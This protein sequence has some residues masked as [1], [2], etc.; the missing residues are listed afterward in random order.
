[1]IGFYVSWIFA[2][3]G[4]S[5]GWIYPF[6][7]LMVYYAL[8]LLRPQFTWH[9]NF[10]DVGNSPSFSQWAAVSTLIGW[11]IKGFGRM[12]MLRWVAVPMGGLALYLASGLYATY[13]NAPA[14]GQDGIDRAWEVL[15][16]QSK[17]GLMALITITLVADPSSVKIF[18]WVAVLS[19]GYLGETFNEWYLQSNVYLFF[20]GWGGIDNNGVA[21]VMVMGVPLAFFFIIN[22]KRWWMKVILFIATGAMVHTVLFS[23][24]RSGQLGLIMVATVLFFVALVALPRKGLTIALAVVFILITLRLAGPEVRARFATIWVDKSEM[25]AS[26]RSRYDTWNA[27]W[28]CIQ[29]HPMGV[30][31]RNFNL[32]SD[33]YGLPADK[34]VHNLFLQTAADYGILGMIGLAVFYVGTCYQAF[35]AALTATARRMGWPRYYCH[36]VTVS[37]AGLLTCSQFIGMEAVEAGYIIAVLGLCTVALIRSIAATEPHTASGKLPELEE[38]VEHAPEDAGEAE[39]QPA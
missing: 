3:A 6:F 5:L 31:P 39:A 11:A 15:T 7:G 12:D 21:M 16:L 24:S 19:L 13:F 9:W 36:M 8:S 30:G 18:G 17:V 2:V 23:F 25:D 14:Q 37:I 20:N 32:I 33:R 35:T 27:A 34:S 10:V 28:M 26:A 4:A 1:M 22:E 29:D 38:V